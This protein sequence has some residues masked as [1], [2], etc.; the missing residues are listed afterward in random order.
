MLVLPSRRPCGP[1]RAQS[2]Q[3]ARAR[4]RP[5]EPQP[6]TG[7]AGEPVRAPWASAV[8]ASSEGGEGEEGEPSSSSSAVDPVGL[9]RWADDGLPA[10][11]AQRCRCFGLRAWERDRGRR[12]G[13]LEGGGRGRSGLKRRELAISPFVARARRERPPTRTAPFTQPKRQPSDRTQRADCCP[14]GVLSWFK[15]TSEGLSARLGGVTD[16]DQRGVPQRIALLPSPLACLRPHNRTRSP[17]RPRTT[18]TSHSHQHFRILSP[19]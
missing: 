13:R 4:T 8:D 19:L 16:R 12:L 10:E 9:G 1:R 14:S 3:R 11:R 6:P 2:P 18:L 17:S 5:G 7:P 15:S